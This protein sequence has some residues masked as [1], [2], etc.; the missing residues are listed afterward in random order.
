M[1]NMDGYID[2]LAPARGEGG[3][4]DIWTHTVY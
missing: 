4:H 2:V 3:T 1:R